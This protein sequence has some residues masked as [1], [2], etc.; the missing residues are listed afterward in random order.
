MNMDQYNAA[1]LAIEP[2]YTTMRVNPTDSTIADFYVACAINGLVI[3]PA[4]STDYIPTPICGF[5]GIPGKN[6]LITA[7]CFIFPADQT[8]P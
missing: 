8:L 7:E 3:M 5:L 2:A 1:R 4:D 6:S